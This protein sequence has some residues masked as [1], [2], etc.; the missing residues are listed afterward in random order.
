MFRIN[1]FNNR[2]T[3]EIQFAFNKDLDPAIGVAN[4]SVRA[5]TPSV[6]SLQVKSIII[7]GHVLAITISPQVPVV[8][9]E[10][11]FAS[12]DFQ[13]FQSVDGE[14]FAEDG[15]ANRFTFI[16]IEGTN[17]VRQT[18]LEAT[19]PVYDVEGPTLVRKHI[20]SLSEQI[21]E[22]LYDIRELGNANYL[23]EEVVDERKTRGPGATDRLE[24]EGAFQVV[25]VSKNPTEARN[26]GRLNFNKTNLTRILGRDY[27][28]GNQLYSKLGSE[29]V[30]L[31]QVVLTETVSNAEIIVNSFDG[32]T[33]NLSKTNIAAIYSVVLNTAAGDRFVY[34]LRNYKYNLNSNKYD[35]LNC[36]GL[37]FLE[38]NQVR[39]AEK[40]VLEGAFQIPEGDDELVVTYAYIDN[41][42]DVIE[43]SVSITRVDSVVREQVGAY[44]TVFSL[45]NYPIVSASDT[46]VLFDGVTFLDPSSEQGT[47]FTELHPAFSVEVE[48]DVTRLPSAPG[49][50]AVDY[51]TGRVFVYGEFTNNGTG[52]FPPVASYNY[53]KIYQPGVDYVVD[54][55]SDE[56]SVLSG[57]SLAGAEVKISFTYDSVLVP[58]IDYVDKANKEVVGEFVDNRYDGALGISTKNYPITNVFEVR[59][60]TTGE[61][62]SVSRFDKYK[63]YITGL[64][65]PR[66]E[67]RF[68]SAEFSRVSNEILH[69]AEEV[70]QV[71]TDRIVKISLFNNNIISYSGGLIASAGNTSLSFSDQIIFASEFFYDY[72]GQ[73]LDENLSKLGAIGDYFVDYSL[74]DIY[75]R[76]AADQDNDF[77]VC[78]YEHGILNPNLSN[79]TSVDEVGYYANKTLISEVVVESFDSD[80]IDLLSVPRSFERYID[81]DSL[82]EVSLGMDQSGVLGQTVLASNIFTAP[83]AVFTETHGAGGFL[84]RFVSGE[85]KVITGYISPVQVLV[86][87]VFTATE[88]DL[89]WTLIDLNFTDGYKCNTRFEIQNVRGVYLVDE[90]QTL[91]ADELTNYFD[92]TKDTIS[93]RTITFNNTLIKN[94]SAGTALVVDYSF[95]N[96]G[97][98]YNYVLDNISV[99]YEYGDNSLDFGLSTSVAPGDIYYTTY[100][101]GALRDKLLSNFGVL[102]QVDEFGVFPLDFDRE[103]YRDF[104]RGSLASFLKGPTKTS[105][106]N[107]VET[108]VGVPPEIREFSFDEWTI[109]R[110]NLHLSTGVLTGSPEFHTSKFGQGIVMAEGDT[111]RY[112]EEAYISYKEGTFEAW[113]RPFWAGL[114]NDAT[115]TFDIGSFGDRATSAGGILVDGRVA[116]SDIYVGAGGF[117]PTEIPFSVT[118]SDIENSPVGKPHQFGQRVGYFIWFD[119]LANRWNLA[120]AASPARN[121]NFTGTVTSSGEFYNVADGYNTLRADGYLEASDFITS[122]RSYISFDGYVD[123]YEVT[124]GYDGYAYADGYLGNDGYTNIAGYLFHDLV[125]FNCDNLHYIFDAG[126]SEAHNRMSLYKDGSGYLNFSVRDS[127]PPGYPERN[128]QFAISHNISDWTADTDYFVSASWRFNTPEGI[129]EMHLGV[130]GQE[131]TNLL[132]FGGTPQAV[133]GDLYRSE[134]VEL[135][136]SGLVKNIISGV[137][138]VTDSGSSVFTSEGADFISN[139]ILAGDTFDILDETADGAAGPYTIV[140]VDSQTQLTLSSALLLSLSDVKFTVNPAAFTV[141]TNID[142]ENFIVKLE[143]DDGVTE[144]AGLDAEA[145]QYY[146]TREDGINTLTITGGALAGDEVKLYTLGLTKGRCRDI[147]Y[148]YESGDTI[149]ARVPA[150]L[151][152]NH[153]DLY[154][155]F[156]PRISIIDAGSIT[157]TNGVWSASGLDITATITDICQ[158]TNSV[159]GKKL[160]FTLGGTDNINFSGTNTVTI[161][162][163]T[164]SGATTET[165]TFT[166]YGVKNTANYFKTITSVDFAFTALD[167]SVS[168]GSISMKELVAFTRSENGGDYAQLF[169]FDNG[170]FRFTIFGSG[171]IPFT[172]EPC[173]YQFDYPISLKINMQSKGDLFLGSD[174]SGNNSFNGV[175]DQVVFLNEML[176]D[177]RAGEVKDTTR[178]ITQDYNNTERAE[179]TPQ[180]LMLT[181]FEGAV[182]PTNKYY[183]NFDDHYL[184]TSNSVNSDFGDALVVLDEGFRIPNDTGYLNNNGGSIELWVSP[185]IDTYQ[186]MLQTR[187]LFDM[188][189]LSSESVSSTTASIVELAG[190]AATINSVRLLGD[191]GDG[192]DYFEGGKLFPDGRRIKLGKSL[193]AQTTDVVV[194]YIPVDFSGDRV[195]IYKDG[196][197]SINFSIVASGLERVVSYPISW[198][199]NTWHR[200]MATWTANSADGD[201]TMRLFVDGVEGGTV[202]YG[203]SGFVWGDGTVYGQAAVGSSAGLTANIDLLDTFGDIWIGSAFDGNALSKARIDN[204]RFSSAA[205]SPAFVA[206]NYVDLNYNANLGSVLPVVEDSLT[207]G[208]F[209]FDKKLDE[210]SF[211]ANVVSESTPLNLFDVIIDDKFG[212][213][214]NDKRARELLITLINR[215]KPAHTSVFIKYKQD[216]A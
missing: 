206:G 36:F 214:V 73:T 80:S 1:A 72:S 160:S 52:A 107:L 143:N 183:V 82:I 200:L 66:I 213:I 134:A 136:S 191:S 132:K 140:S 184:T 98:Q 11:L 34:D 164:Y 125:Q 21:G 211:L 139:G 7:Q 162:G 170:E 169:N 210:T 147:F 141:Q 85:E 43:D 172:L 150:P 61:Q 92:A 59:N 174:L 209:D 117:N 116:L 50:F 131:V 55:D 118:R 100:R 79:I 161:N 119:D 203:T 74:G 187:Y 193:P 68:E 4:I 154:K 91:P 62:Y 96:L 120:W 110:D 123:G 23:Y 57:R 192:K 89:A 153:F 93:D 41:G 104:A 171:G 152:Y 180:T 190:K 10:V 135:L 155:I 130:N 13:P 167:A 129:D 77:G 156:I 181:N 31:R 215:M 202:T 49:E 196:Y 145:P 58:G 199:R 14:K 22:T 70:S 67:S 106:S 168:L 16:G 97:V 158:P 38:S 144:L 30:S 201:D 65:L 195:S 5:V 126:P 127:G 51:A 208:I 48:Y 146:I 18:L 54:Y 128:K 133:S 53:R 205:R 197:G 124:D 151:D 39:L 26:A 186:D 86:D 40:A 33:L 148:S 99:S 121:I 78:S 159:T 149:K 87:S 3:Q 45:K 177:I 6:P 19:P 163:T 178:T 60:Q 94:V 142:V 81:A 175:L 88:T 46:T 44:Q 28:K 111:L 138:G 84:L 71:L 173:Y 157:N 103:L 42:I 115:L 15:I 165:L 12:T 166:D 212:R 9:Y 137:N 189:A 69:I 2:S 37:S 179:V 122:T 102:T 112:P 105:I 114:D 113:I 198:Q 216:G 35:S 47:P 20:S 75:V 207:S 25:R 83:D 27:L 204:L 109:D 194:S 8:T 188:T 24:Q 76:V 32:L 101:Y 64:N 29:P 17:E 182:E 176:D 56:V 90:L 63:V 185:M 95:G 108:V